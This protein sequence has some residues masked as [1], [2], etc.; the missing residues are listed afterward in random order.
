MI[1]IPSRQA[2]D[3][4]PCA[5][6]PRSL[7]ALGMTVV[8]ACAGTRAGASNDLLIV[9]Y[10]RE[11]DTMNRYATHILEDIQSCVVEGLVTSDEHMNI[12]P[13]LAAEIPTLENGG[14][15]L[16][17]CLREWR[18]EAARRRWNGRHVEV[19][20]RREMARRQA[21]HVR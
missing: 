4:G 19:A 8:L 20:S 7:A 10:D 14:V 16:T 17:G 9:G 5:R 18:R 15:K 12:V 2:R 11:P 3:L 13:V 6:V 21:A 1:V